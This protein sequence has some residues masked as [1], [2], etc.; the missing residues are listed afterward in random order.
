MKKNLEIQTNSKKGGIMSRPI[1]KVSPDWWDYTTLDP[2]ILNDVPQ[3]DE[4]DLLEFSRP[5]LISRIMRVPSGVPSV[6]QSSEPELSPPHARKKIV[7][8]AFVKY[9]GVEPGLESAAKWM[10]L[11]K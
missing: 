3:I 10:S 6:F 7:S 1:S 2:E 8:P 4:K 11:T 5:G 9:L